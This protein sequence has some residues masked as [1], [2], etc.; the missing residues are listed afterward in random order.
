MRSAQ[1]VIDQLHQRLAVWEDRGTRKT[2]DLIPFCLQSTLPFRAPAPFVEVCV[3][4]GNRL[5][6]GRIRTESVQNAWMGGDKNEEDPVITSPVSCWLDHYGPRFLWAGTASPQDNAALYNRL[7]V[8]AERGLNGGL[9][10]FT[11]PLMRHADGSGSFLLQLI[12][13][14]ERH[15][16][17]AVIQI[18]RAPLA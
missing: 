6:K 4:P 11:F 13:F 9:V 12:N 14:D 2:L 3:P 15:L 8:Y 17:Q 1:T 10:G 7:V 18:Q 16:P 5:L